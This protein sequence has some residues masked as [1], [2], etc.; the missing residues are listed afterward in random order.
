MSPL[1]HSA[2]SSNCD[3]VVLRQMVSQ[4]DSKRLLAGHITFGFSFSNGCR[5]QVIHA[6][7]TTEAL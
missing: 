2:T 4:V 1:E 7:R 6:L 5:E 3:L